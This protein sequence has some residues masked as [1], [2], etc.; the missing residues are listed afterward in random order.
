MKVEVKDS[1]E[2]KD[3]VSINVVEKQNEIVPFDKRSI[4]LDVE[5]FTNFIRCLSILKD[6]SNDADIQEGF[7]RQRINDQSTIFE[8]NLTNIFSSVNLPITSLKLILDLLKCFAKKEVTLQLNEKNFTFSD[9]FSSLTFELPFIE[10]LDNKYINQ[11]DLDSMYPV[12]EQDL[13]LRCE[14]NKTISD[15][16]KIICQGF[17]VNNLQINLKGESASITTK[18][19]SGD[20][21]ATIVKNI[22]TQKIIENDSYIKFPIVPFIIDHDNDIILEVYEMSNGICVCK[23]ITKASIIDI[24]T[25]SRNHIKLVEDDIEEEE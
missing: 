11:D 4:K 6:I 17:N 18:T 2:V 14:I 10:Y 5:S 3:N 15:R 21:E 24:V 13:I 25:F 12:T 16:I 20:K 23:L 9:E 8:M 1:L 7:I 22:I 19:Q